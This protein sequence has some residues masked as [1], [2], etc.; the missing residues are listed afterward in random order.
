MLN[1]N[2][3][4]LTETPAGRELI[5]Q[6]EAS[7]EAK[8]LAI[9]REQFQ[10]RQRLLGRRE[11]DVPEARRRAEAATSRAA[12]ALKRAHVAQDEADVAWAAAN[13]VSVNVDN[14]LATAEKALRD[15]ASPLLAAFITETHRLEHDA[16]RRGDAMAGP[17]NRVTGKHKPLSSFAGVAY[18]LDEVRRAR[19]EAEDSKLEPL[20]ASELKA[21]I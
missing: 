1:L 2:D 9:Q 11:R 18:Y 16:Q 13:Q 12:D 20:T 10:V 6:L 7:A 3:A 17:V 21:R 5:S 15:A 4:L 14:A 8:R 19:G